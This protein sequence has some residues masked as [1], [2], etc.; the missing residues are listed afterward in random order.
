MAGRGR[1]ADR[2]RATSRASGPPGRIARERRRTRAAGLVRRAASVAI[3]LVGLTA[4]GARSRSTRSPT[5]GRSAWRA[6]TPRWPRPPASGAS[7]GGSATCR[8]AS[9][10]AELGSQL[11]RRAVRC[12]A[13]S[14]SRS[15]RP[16]GAVRRGVRCG[17]PAVDGGEERR[18]GDAPGS[19]PGQGARRRPAPSPGTARRPAR[20]RPTSASRPGPIAPVDSADEQAEQDGGDDGPEQRVEQPADQAQVVGRGPAHGAPAAPRRRPGPGTASATATSPAGRHRRGRQGTEDRDDRQHAELDRAWPRPGCRSRRRSPGRPARRRP[21]RSDRAGSPA[22][23]R[24]AAAPPKVPGSEGAVQGLDPVGVARPARRRRRPG[25]AP[26]RAQR[27]GRAGRTTARSRSGSQPATRGRA[28]RPRAG[29]RA[30]CRR[31][32]RRR[33]ATAGPK[34]RLPEHRVHGRSTSRPARRATAH[35][36]YAA[37]SPAS[38]SSG[39]SGVRP[40]STRNPCERR[41]S[42]ARRRAERYAA[43]AGHQG[44]AERRQGE[45]PAGVADGHVLQQQPAAGRDPEGLGPAGSDMGRR[46]PDR[47]QR[48]RNDGQADPGSPEP[49]EGTEQVATACSLGG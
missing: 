22:D 34:R 2:R 3:S 11:T 44:Q 6:R 10:A 37:V 21:T 14:V 20:A 24:R 49:A 38:A 1:R 32:P 23:P 31:R 12:R 46:R 42:A 26:R 33:P 30:A 18:T 45:V 13:R 25:P 7:T 9:S 8:T 4:V 43:S 29:A 27:P 28:A 36:A 47:Q 5:N 19:R 17:P 39:G 40:R 35:P 48:D 15:A 41:G 16:V